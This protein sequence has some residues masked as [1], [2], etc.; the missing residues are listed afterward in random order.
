M[1]YYRNR[2]K[3][4]RSKGSKRKK[5]NLGQI[6]SDQQD[7]AKWLTL[8]YIQSLFQGRKKWNLLW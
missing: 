6:L 5:R 8:S 2:K 3:R 7:E 4:S 1:S